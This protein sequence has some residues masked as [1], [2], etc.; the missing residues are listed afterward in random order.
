MCVREFVAL[1]MLTLIFCVACDSNAI[2]LIILSYK[3]C[4]SRAPKLTSVSLLYYS[5]PE[6]AGHRQR[7]PWSSLL[8]QRHS[9]STLLNVTSFCSISKNN[10]IFIFYLYYFLI[11]GAIVKL[12]P[13][14]VRS[15]NID[16]LHQ[17]IACLSAGS[18]LSKCP[19]NR[20]NITLLNSLVHI[21]VWFSYQL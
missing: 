13:R 8:F 9:I 1:D 7:L 18:P 16:I 2:I 11:L 17:T 20:T 14:H 6:N 4:R 5:L 21:Y 12:I 15:Y 10:E 19:S 3:T